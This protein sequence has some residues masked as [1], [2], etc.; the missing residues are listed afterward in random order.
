MDEAIKGRILHLYTVEKLS[1][2]QI[3]EQLHIGRKAAAGV[4]NDSNCEKTSALGQKV[5]NIDPYKS[6][7][8]QWYKEY[9]KLKSIQIYE[10]LKEYG[11][12]GGYR[13]VSKYTLQYRQKKNEYYHA[14]TFV[15]GEES[16]VDWF[17]VTNLSFGV[18]YAFVMVL[19]YSRYSWGKFYPRNSF[20][21]FLDGHIECFRKFN[22][23]THTYRYDNL[24]SVVLSRYPETRYNPQFLEFARHYGFGIHLCNTYSAY[25]KG[26]VEKKGQDVR[27]FLYGNTFKDINNLNDKFY[28][29]LDKRN[30]IIHRSTNRK[31]NE[32]F[33]EEKL[34]QLPVKEYSPTRII[35]AVLVSKTGFIQFEMNKYS[36]P[37]TCASKNADII[38][39]PEKLE[40]IINN[41][42]VALHKRIFSKNQTI[43]N[44][45]HREKIL[46]ITPK[47]K[48]QRIL[49]LMQSMDN[50]IALF[51]IKAE[52]EGEDKLSYA[53]ELFKLLKLVSRNT[54]IW[55]IK[56]A[57]SVSAYKLKAVLS[58]LDLPK[59]KENNPVY[60]KDTNLLNIKYKERGLDSYDRHE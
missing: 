5:F 8:G 25:E 54:L 55:A 49:Q 30:D 45:M 51:L 41:S 24:K 37:N 50:D 28:A 60:P 11:Y 47:Y 46:E 16:Q 36:V 20:E 43:E 35:P 34:I 12:K 56:K 32:M 48:Q 7:I 18:V 31:P 26:R 6:L 33:K 23:I 42:R 57:C 19:S 59:E 4:I 39:Y 38:A 2:R 44:P 40:V 13:T 29:Y 15:S 52:A 17:T 9:P 58:L 1:I 3:A 10:R 27:S 22:G 21:F 53:Y 14:L